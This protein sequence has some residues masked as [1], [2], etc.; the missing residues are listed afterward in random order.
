MTS[1]FSNVQK[2][3]F[4]LCFIEI[5]SVGI[6]GGV[7][8]AMWDC[9]PA[10]IFVQP[11]GGGKGWVSTT[12]LI[13]LPFFALA[14]TSG[15]SDCNG[16]QDVSDVEWAKKIEQQK[17]LVSNWKELSEQTAQGGGPHLSGLSSLMGCPKE[18]HQNFAEMLRDDFEWLFAGRM[19]TTETPEKRRIQ[20]TTLIGK[21]P[22][23]SQTCEMEG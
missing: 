2:I 23:L 11:K 5:I 8:S 18:Q 19:E 16:T 7:W 15:T 9:G 13:F 3:L 17:F 22:Q 14:S 20:I 21:H 4:V 6:P 1:L 12:N 10:T